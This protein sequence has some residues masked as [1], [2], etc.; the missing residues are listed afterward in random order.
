MTGVSITAG[1]VPGSWV[2]IAGANIWAIADLDPGDAVA[3]SCRDLIRGGAPIEHV[4]G[5]LMLGRPRPAESFAVAG[6]SRAA[7]RVVVCGTAWAEVTPP[8]GSELPMRAESG[9][10]AVEDF[11]SFVSVSLHAAGP[12]PDAHALPLT[13]G[14]VAASQVTVVVAADGG[15][16]TDDPPASGGSSGNPFDVLFGNTVRPDP[17][18]GPAPDIPEDWKLWARPAEAAVQ[19]GPHTLPPIDTFAAPEPVAQPSAGPLPGPTAGPSAAS[20][21]TD[22]FS[23]ALPVESPAPPFQPQ[24]SHPPAVHPPSAPYISTDNAH[25]RSRPPRAPARASRPMGALRLST[26]DLIPLDGGVVLGR[27]PGNPDRE[28]PYRIQVAGDDASISRQHAAVRVDGSSAIVTD[29]NSTNGT[30]VQP[31]G[32]VIERVPA[33]GSRLIEVGTVIH[34]G[35]E[36]WCRFEVAP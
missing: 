13:G 22:D 26:G 31:P 8:R 19:P 17:E 11:E 6:M 27:A 33:G 28:F 23:W 30:F 34:L 10:L 35:D 2:A 12:P 5:A 3:A 14:V 4:V 32:G 20:V 1:Y 7:A 9:L 24:S 25:T 15:S 21:L 18:A 29:L 16:T 36:I